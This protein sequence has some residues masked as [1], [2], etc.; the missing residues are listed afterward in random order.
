MSS[1]RSGW[2][3]AVFCAGA[4]VGLVSSSTL[5]SSDAYA[6][7]EAER[8]A[9]EIQDARDRANAAAQA[10]FDAESRI[11]QLDLE[12]AAKEAE[13]AKMEA[14]VATLRDSLSAAAV[15][16]FTQGITVGNPL[17]T[18]VDGMNSQATAN[19]FASAA[20]GRT[21]ANMDDF[22]AAIDELEDVRA[23]LDDQQ[24]EAQA[25][26]ESFEALKAQAEAEVVRLQEIEEQ[27]LEDEAVQRE[28]EKLRA[29]EAEKAAQEAA[30]AQAAADAQAQADAAAAA[31]QQPQAAANPAPADNVDDGGGAPADSGGGGT[32]DGGD[33]DGGDDAPEPAPTPEPP[34]PP[35]PPR[36]G[37]VCPVQGA[38]AYADTWGA[39]RSGGRSHQ[40][41]DM[42]APSGTPLVAVVSGSVNFKQ[43]RLGGNSIW[44][45]GSDGNR[46]FYAH[47]S[48][49]AGSSRSVSQGEVIGYVGS[50]GN[51]YTP[52]LHFEVH[53]GG[54]VAVNPYPYVRAVC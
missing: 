30:A 17:F 3:R 31:A 42:M 38:V 51:A 27:R 40:G 12:I 23:D 49:F 25:E 10:M 24:A 44:L 45:S 6:D 11:D 54:G 14:D 13:V 2:W 43:T 22:A 9:R 52:H 35:P 32:S 46:Y 29:A 50:T 47:L 5:I 18:P 48:A 37:M 39:A 28:L 20:T 4:L 1:A 33:S 26:R 19:V 34:A 8:A 21:L 36:P 7:S 16:R 41:V 53:P 15:Q